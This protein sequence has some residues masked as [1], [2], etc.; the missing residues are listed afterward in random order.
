[1]DQ[2]KNNMEMTDYPVDWVDVYGRI[3]DEGIIAE[4]AASFLKNSQTLILSLKSAVNA[5]STD[6]IEL[7]AHALK[8]S[9][10]NIGAIVLAKAA[11]QLEK[12]GSEKI[13]HDVDEQFA[14]V[15]QEYATLKELFEYPDWMERAKRAAKVK[16]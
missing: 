7:Y 10:S 4:F 16:I 9:A 6:Q 12:A 1:M 11:W 15:E 5:H 2:Q 13:V 8:G 3:G 14:V